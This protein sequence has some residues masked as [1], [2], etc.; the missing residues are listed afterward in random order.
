[1]VR[2]G[3]DITLFGGA[4][5]GTS[6]EADTLL[7]H[8]SRLTI[9]GIFHHT[10]YTIQIAFDLLKSGKVDSEPFISEVRPLEDVVE[11]LESHGRQEGIKH[12]TRP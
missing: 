8:F 5:F 10:P 7:L 3:R 6:I 12:E 11:A 4:P 2:K 1:M 9:R